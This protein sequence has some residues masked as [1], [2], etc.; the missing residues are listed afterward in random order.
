[1]NIELE[2]FLYVVK[3]NP[4]A[5]APY[6]NNK[7]IIDMTRIAQNLFMFYSEEEFFTPKAMRVL[8]LACL[9]HDF[10]HSGGKE[11]DSV[12]I[13]NACKAANT[14]L[15]NK[16]QATPRIIDEVNHAINC[17]VYPFSVNPVG[18]MEQCIRDADVLYPTM[19]QEPKVIMESLREEISVSQ[20]RVISYEEMLEGQKK[21]M[22]SVV[23]YTEPGKRIMSSMGDDYMKSLEKYAYRFDANRLTSELTSDLLKGY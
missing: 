23:L 6:H 7:H 3:N 13:R 16:S 14:F 10:N 20:D 18:V 19:S 11:E 12:N 17:T 1:M 9:F 5:N 15:L 4:S 2:T 21:F 8:T 22:E